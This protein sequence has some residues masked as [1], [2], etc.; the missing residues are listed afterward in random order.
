MK[1]FFA[2][3]DLFI[4]RRASFARVTKDGSRE[5][6]FHQILN[7]GEASMKRRVL[8]MATA[9][10]FAATAAFAGAPK[11]ENAWLTEGFSNPE[12]VA[13]APDGALF[14]SNVNGEGGARDGNGFI[15]RV[16]TSGEILD[17]KFIEGLDAPKGMAVHD[18]LL[19]VADIDIVRIFDAK[20]G[21][22]LD[23]A[24]ID[25]ARFLNDVTVWQDDVFVSDSGTGRIWRFTGTSIDLWREGED[26]R[27]VNGLSGAGDKM[28]VSTMTS[29]SLFE[30]TAKGGWRQIATGMED[31]DGI[32][33][34]KGGF[35]VSSWPGKIH[36]VGK[37]GAVT[38]VLDTTAKNIFQN[39]LTM[40]DGLVIVPNWE[41]GTVTAWRVK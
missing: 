28:F 41:P 19:F 14:I 33:V 18:G 35:L 5:P 10:S 20:T 24:P 16:S 38:T 23:G 4:L 15:S 22:A 37:R 32:G 31:A 36:H 3:E 7:M 25:G 40:I 6:I 27:G 39:D 26:L 13:E 21:E 17:L 9:L 12:G 29:G 11:L 8:G 1:S 34:M 30:A 2:I